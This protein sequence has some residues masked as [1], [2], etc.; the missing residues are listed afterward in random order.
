MPAMVGQCNQMP[1]VSMGMS[2]TCAFF[3]QGDSSL[4]HC[5]SSRKLLSE[6]RGSLG[7]CHVSGLPS[8]SVQNLQENTVR[9]RSG[10]PS[11]RANFYNANNSER[12]EVRPT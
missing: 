6:G 4:R 7:T 12:L 3:Q 1:V 8:A 11:T 2:S 9:A 10:M 5:R